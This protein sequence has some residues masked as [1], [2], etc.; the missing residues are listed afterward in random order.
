MYKLAILGLMGLVIMTA[1]GNK[2]MIKQMEKPV[3]TTEVAAKSRMLYFGAKWCGPCKQMK[4]I[5]KDKKVKN[6]LD[7]LDF[8]MYDID[9]DSEMKRQFQVSVVP[10]MIFIDKDGIMRRYTGAMSKE[11]FIKIIESYI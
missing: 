5:F 10:T 9:V 4:E 7:K 11:S 6:L 3:D 1:N 2:E 8:K